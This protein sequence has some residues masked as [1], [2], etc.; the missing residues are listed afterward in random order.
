MK[1]TKDSTYI[2]GGVLM[3]VVGSVLFSTKA[4]FV[5]LTYGVYPVD[6]IALL[7]LRMLFSLPFFLISAALSSNRK[8]NIR[9]TSKQWA[10]VAVL[11]LLGY[12]VS[13]FLDFV[14]LQY[15]TAGIERLILFTYPTFV[16]IISALFLKKPAT[17]AQWIAIILAYG[18]LLIA[19]GAEVQLQPTSD[20]YLGCL[21]IL[22]CALTFAIYIAGSGVLIPSVGALKFN[23]YAMS[24]A[25]VAVVIHFLLVSDQSL[26]GLPAIVYI[27]A[28]AMAIIGTVLPSYLVSLGIKRLGSNTTS[29]IASIGPVSTII[30]AHYLLDETF[31][32]VQGIG[33]ALIIA[34]IM[35]I[36]WK[37]VPKVQPITEVPASA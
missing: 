18:G 35:V 10:L 19:Y 31:S 22:V 17:P 7:A 16:L 4:I 33:T 25:G 12:Y 37:R 24:F 29:I 34:G 28:V 14:G 15:V 32:L 2:I 11:G 13:S 23:S 21:L 1:I 30:Q 27:Y 20:F 3:G 8:E 26:L 9:F 6:P 36:S 5:K